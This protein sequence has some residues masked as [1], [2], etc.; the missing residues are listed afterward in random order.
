M[1]SS[2]GAASRSP[3][4]ASSK[5]SAVY[6]S[7]PLVEKAKLASAAALDLGAV[8]AFDRVGRWRRATGGCW[9]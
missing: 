3:S 2:W 8:V 7:R 5:L 6:S 9:R 4:I 1:A